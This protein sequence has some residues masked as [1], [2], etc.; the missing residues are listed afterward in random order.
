MPSAFLCHSSGDK[1]VVEE[2][3][4]FLEGAGVDVWID[5]ARMDIGDSLIEKISVG[6]KETNY[7][8]A[9][10]SASSV[11]SGWVQKELRLAMTTEILNQRVV[12]MPV[13]LDDC[14]IPFF[15][16]DKLYADFRSSERQQIE[17]HRLLRAILK[18]PS[19]TRDRSPE[20]GE[21]ISER[22]ESGGPR[23]IAESWPETPGVL[24]HDVRQEYFGLRTARNHKNNGFAGLALGLLVGMGQYSGVITFPGPFLLVAGLAGAGGV[25]FLVSGVS[26]EIAFTEDKNLLLSIEEV[27]G[28]KLPFDRRWHLQRHAGSHSKMYIVAHMA[29]TVAAV[30]TVV[31]GV[32]VLLTLATMASWL[33]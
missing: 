8:V 19:A 13:V 28:W 9:F 20:A 12:V 15:L 5:S 10:I 24:V 17:K 18:T 26:F 7:L 16:R 33:P 14:E 4:R 30:L 27:G 2:L 11:Q 22:L 32:C 25:L 1:A 6:I 23:M 3:A 31:L 21:G 29:E